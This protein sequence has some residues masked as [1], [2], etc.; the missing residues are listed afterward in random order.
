M[1]S[2][3]GVQKVWTKLQYYQHQQPL[4]ESRAQSPD[5]RFVPTTT[6]VWYSLRCVSAVAFYR[7]LGA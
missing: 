5:T 6:D 2:T 4:I 7:W 3:C 1:V